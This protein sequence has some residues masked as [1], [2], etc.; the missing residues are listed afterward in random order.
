MNG[1]HDEYAAMGARYSPP[2]VECVD[3]GSE[4]GTFDP[5]DRNANIEDDATAAE[6]SRL[7]QQ[8]K[9]QEVFGT[10]TDPPWSH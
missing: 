3:F 2:S 6:N 1:P 5:A 7:Q 10:Q 9:L 8:Q 4:F